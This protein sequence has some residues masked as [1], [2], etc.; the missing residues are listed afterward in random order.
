MLYI[1]IIHIHIHIFK[2][3]VNHLFGKIAHREI[4]NANI[5]IKQQDKNME[6]QRERVTSEKIQNTNSQK[7]FERYRSNYIIL[8]V[9]WI[10]QG[11][12]MCARGG[13]RGAYLIK[14]CSYRPISAEEST[15]NEWEKEVRI[16]AQYAR[17]LIIFGCFY[18]VKSR[19]FASP[20]LTHFAS[21]P[22][23]SVCSILIRIS[24]ISIFLYMDKFMFLESFL[25]CFILSRTKIEKT[26][27]TVL[28][29]F[30]IDKIL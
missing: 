18:G 21:Y 2:Y 22:F 5:S 13:E 19:G 10:L 30:L 25:T 8:C 7:E 3:I 15:W 27:C 17:N 28:D 11:L 24:C 14:Y 20:Q 26:L 6:R 9:C 29:V 4:I 23:F 12:F 1:N 16:E